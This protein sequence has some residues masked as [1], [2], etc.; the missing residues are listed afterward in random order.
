MAFINEYENVANGFTGLG[1]Q[2]FDELFK[3][4]VFNVSLTK[5][6][7]E[8]AE[9]P[10]GRLAETGHEIFAAL[11]AIDGFACVGE[12]VVN[13]FV[14]FGAIGDD[15]DAGVG[16]V[17]E[18]PLG[19]EHHC[20]AFATALSVPDDA[21]LTIADVRLGGLDAEVLVDA[22]EFFDACVEEDEVAEDIE[23]AGF[24]ADFE[25]VFVEFVAAVVLLVFFPGE[26][27]FFGGADR[28][29]AQ[30]FGVVACED[31]LDGAEEG[32]D[33]FGLLVGKALADAFADFFAAVF[34][35]D[36]AD[37]NAVDVQDNIGAFFF[38][39]L[40][41]DFFS[42][43]EVVGFWVFPVDELDGFGVLAGGGFDLNAVAQEFVDFFVVVVEAAGGLVGCG[44]EFVE[45]LADLGGCVALLGEVGGEEL[46]FDVAVAFAVFPVA[47]VGVVEFV[48]EEGDDA[49]L[50]V[51]FWLAD[52][53]HEMS[54]LH[55]LIILRF[56]VLS[57]FLS[58]FFV[59]TSS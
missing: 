1:F 32:A 19:E 55:D 18:Y 20:D 2:V 3:V 39:A 46:F 6:V 58:A 17:F 50:G 56:L 44:V 59:C 30:S 36:N 33:E 15:D 8:G 49:V 7:D 4:F 14:K 38:F 10:G 13:L 57:C 29:V 53:V 9:E 24:S 21:A 47:E 26:E 22:G 34:K 11:G 31:D 25:Q 37:R 45:G 51:A 28:A 16:D 54:K 40:D 23:E 27:V 12:Y 42:D 43:R 5:F 41:G 48:T 35:F 52:I